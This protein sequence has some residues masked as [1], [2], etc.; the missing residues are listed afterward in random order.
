MAQ[1]RR[2][3]SERSRDEALAIG[4][5]LTQ[6]YDRLFPSSADRFW[7]FRGSLDMTQQQLADDCGVSAGVI[8]NLECGYGLPK[9]T[10]L[11]KLAKGAGISTDFILNLSSKREISK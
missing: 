6:M 5:Q 7:A 11:I 4:R 8:S 10:T 9:G 3:L 1:R 2:K